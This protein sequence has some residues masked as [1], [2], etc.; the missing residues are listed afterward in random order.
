MIW[1]HI[2]AA[3]IA[4][5]AGAIAMYALKGASLHRKSGT[6][7]VWTMLVMSSTGAIVAMMRP[8]RVSVIAGALTFYLVA[9]AFVTVRRPHVA[10]KA[11]DIG[12]T[13]FAFI[14]G[15]V[16]LYFGF[17]AVTNV[18]GTLDGYPPQPYFVFSGV[19]LL[20]AVLDGRMLLKG[21]PTGKHRIARHLWRMCFAMLIA[22]MSFFLGQAKLFPAPLQNFALLSIPVITVMAFSI[23]WLARVLFAKRWQKV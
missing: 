18:K 1:L 21:A 13:L 23:Y 2:V 20:G 3:S 10:A 22:T 12:A 4:L 9:T 8:V 11:I 6:L 17:E 14:V 19:A 15:V 7:F 5:I 16:G